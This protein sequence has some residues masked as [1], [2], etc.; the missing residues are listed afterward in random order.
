MKQQTV[1]ALKISGIFLAGLIV[2]AILMNIL[3]MY[4]R[5]AYREL[6]RINL[7]TDE[8]F[9]A[10][11]ASRQ[12]N[13]LEAA[14]HRWNVVKLDSGEGFQSLTRDRDK[15]QDVFMLPFALLGYRYID[16]YYKNHPGAKWLQGVNHGLLAAALDDIGEHDEALK[17]WEQSS[18]ILKKQSTEDTRKLISSLL[19][20]EKSDLYI[21]AEKKVLE[22]KN[23]AQQKNRGD[24]E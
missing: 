14:L 18:R 24:G 4:V 6:L 22:E 10:S 23:Q 21:Q 9:L 11:R 13:K 8:K 19:E 2:G 15:E 12:N 17:Q 3:H 7:A 1:K 16:S 5:P 20:Q